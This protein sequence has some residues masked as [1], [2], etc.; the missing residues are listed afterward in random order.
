M[1]YLGM[2][3][4]L[5]GL[6]FMFVSW[7]KTGQISYVLAGLVV[8]GVGSLITQQAKKRENQ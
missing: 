3:L 7:I 1:K 2:A 5:G 4:M 8:T 6:L